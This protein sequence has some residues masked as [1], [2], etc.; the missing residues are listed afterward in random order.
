MPE[1][2][3][4]TDPISPFTV[5]LASS[6]PPLAITVVTPLQF[7]KPMAM[8]VQAASLQYYGERAPW[9][10]KDLRVV[11]LALL[12]NRMCSVLSKDTDDLLLVPVHL[13]ESIPCAWRCGLLDENCEFNLANWTSACAN[14]MTPKE[15]E[16]CW[17]DAKSYAG[18]EL[19]TKAYYAARAGKRCRRGGHGT[20]KR[21]RMMASR[22]EGGRV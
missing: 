6:P 20:Q 18:R 4:P 22:M 5:A 9:W 10:M 7:A 19:A 21:G 15:A 8:A 2:L 1:E 14:P 16:R 17:R 11:T 12:R 13:T 3:A